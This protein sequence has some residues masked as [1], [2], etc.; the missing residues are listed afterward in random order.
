MRAARETALALDDPGDQE[1]H[2]GAPRPGG[3]PC[4]VLPPH[5]RQRRRRR[6]P[7]PARCHRGVRLLIGLEPL[8]I[9][10]ARRAHGG[11]EPRP[12]M[13]RLWVGQGRPL[14]DHASAAGGRWGGGCRGPAPPGAASASGGQTNHRAGPRGLG[15]ATAGASGPGAPAYVEGGGCARGR[16]WTRTKRQAARATRP[17]RSSTATG[18]SLLGPCPQRGASSCVRP[19]VATTRGQAGGGRPQGASACRRAHGRGP[20]VPRPLGRA[21]PPPTGQRRAAVRAAPSPG[22]PSRPT[23]SPAALATGVATLARRGP[24]RTPPRRGR[25]PAPRPPRRRRTWVRASRPSGLGPEAGRGARALGG[26]S[27]DAPESA[28]GVVS[29]GSQGGG[30]A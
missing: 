25:P 26:A 28:R 19:G 1:A 23:A 16:A 17:S 3:H 11:G 9:G 2:A 5:G 18:R 7:A 10:P 8:G 21:R 27:A 24:S 6:A 12:A 30:M 22:T 4:G 15:A 20:N 29:C 13:V 14:H